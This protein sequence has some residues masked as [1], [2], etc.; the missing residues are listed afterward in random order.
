MSQPTKSNALS[1]WIAQ[2]L[3]AILSI[4]AMVGTGW[5]SIGAL[6]TRVDENQRAIIQR[7]DSI[8]ARLTRQDV[9]RTCMIRNIDRLADRSGVALPCEGGE[10]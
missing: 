10:E 7:L 6:Q 9:A 5:A 3:W 4:T 1:D 8:D 2:N